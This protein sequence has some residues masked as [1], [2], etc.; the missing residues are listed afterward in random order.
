L[1]ERK[2]NGR[3]AFGV[4]RILFQAVVELLMKSAKP[5]VINCGLANVFVRKN[6]VA[7]SEQ[8]VYC[9]TIKEPKG[10]IL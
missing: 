4:N 9:G 5:V 7:V 10:V 6:F 2:I 3:P 8:Y 1:F